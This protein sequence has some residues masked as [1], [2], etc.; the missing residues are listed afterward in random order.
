MGF[1]YLVSKPI[2][3]YHARRSMSRHQGLLDGLETDQHPS[4]LLEE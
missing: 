4:L 1:I 2:R 3:N